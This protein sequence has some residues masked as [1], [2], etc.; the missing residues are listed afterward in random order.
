[1][2]VCRVWQVESVEL[3]GDGGEV[4]R[5]RLAKSVSKVAMVVFADGV[6]GTTSEAYRSRERCVL[7]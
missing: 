7:R 6:S 2:I 5:D 4:Y 1:V 3:V